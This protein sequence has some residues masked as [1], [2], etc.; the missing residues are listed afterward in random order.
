MVEFKGR[1]GTSVARPKKMVVKCE[2]YNLTNLSVKVTNNYDDANPVWYNATI[3]E[4]VTLA[5]D[6]KESTNW[7][8][9][10]HCYGETIDLNDGYFKE[11]YILLEV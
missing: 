2:T 11:P 9:G 4:E 3:G 5:N 8:I 1:A 10:I 7:A 6:S